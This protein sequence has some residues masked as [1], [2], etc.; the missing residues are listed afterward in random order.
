MTPPND[1]TAADDALLA[2]LTQDENEEDNAPSSS[3]TK[4]P[5][6]RSSRLQQLNR[7]KQNAD[8]LANHSMAQAAAL[9]D[10]TASGGTNP[11]VRAQ[12]DHTRA[13][14]EHAVRQAGA[15]LLTRQANFARDAAPV[16][17]AGSLER[18]NSRVAST[19]A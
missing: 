4:S 5:A 14:A 1:A 9:R 13:V 17:S 6:Q 2:A 7:E 12:D 3:Q 16:E 8:A 11:T 15:D 10:Q 19:S 18:G